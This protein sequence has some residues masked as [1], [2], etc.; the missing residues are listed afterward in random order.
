MTRYAT[1]LLI[2]FFFIINANYSI[3]GE[4]GGISLKA[5]KTHTSG[6]YSNYFQ[7]GWSWGFGA[8]FEL[9]IVYKYL[10]TEA[11]IIV[12][13]RAMEDS[14]DSYLRMYAIH[15]G[16]GLFW[17]LWR[18]AV[19]YSGIDFQE[20]YIQFHADILD[21]DESSFKPG[22][23]LKA[24]VFIPL[25]KNIS[26]RVGINHTITEI[27]DKWLHS[28][29]F[30]VSGIF[31][32]PDG[33]WIVGHEKQKAADFVYKEN[34]DV[35]YHEGVVK[36][37]TGEAEQAEISFKRV[38]EIDSSHTEAKEM[39]QK[40]GT[41]KE[42]YRKASELIKE[43][44]YFDAIAPLEKSIPYIKTA[45]SELN[46]VR[47]KLLGEVPALERHGIEAYEKKEYDRCISIMNRIRTIDPENTTAA[48]YLPRAVRRKEAIERLK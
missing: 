48:L 38:L 20:L 24:G 35:I 19:P 4:V 30:A 32:Y 21:K 40:I 5:E 15:A 27:S 13:Q 17:P 44:K 28:S 14:A 9:P 25:H 6:Y 43:Q 39:L 11:G 7:D 2:C 37:N 41:A 16:A 26:L 31:R 1:F 29:S 45:S 47:A 3:G 42:H 18:Y 34:T 10:F 22:T 36:A 46:L 12:D 8:I 33:I 23:L